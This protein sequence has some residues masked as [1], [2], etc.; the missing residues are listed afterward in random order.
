MMNPATRRS[1]RNDQLMEGPLD[2]RLDHGRFIG[3]SGGE[4]ESREKVLTEGPAKSFLKC[5][6]C[7]A[8]RW[9]SW[10]SARRG[11]TRW[12]KLRQSGQHQVNRE[13]IFGDQHHLPLMLLLLH[14]EDVPLDLS[15]VDPSRPTDRLH[16]LI[17]IRK[18]QAHP[19]P[20]DPSDWD[21]YSSSSSQRIPGHP[22]DH[23]VHKNNIQGRWKEEKRYRVVQSM[24]WDNSINTSDQDPSMESPHQPFELMLM[25]ELIVITWITASR[26]RVI[27]LHYVRT[28]K[29]LT[30][31]ELSGLKFTPNCGKVSER[32]LQL[33]KNVTKRVIPVTSWPIRSTH[34]LNMISQGQSKVNLRISTSSCH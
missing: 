17:L 29:A 34:S 8:K 12:G 9:S 26:I 25:M 14:L 24:T 13:G 27:H 18:N 6:K 5:V 23:A 21:L 16:H 2:H 7:N 30:F 31:D 32:H 20:H 15:P 11:E 19:V 28:I 3:W 10:K 4:S 22:H 1:I 33:T